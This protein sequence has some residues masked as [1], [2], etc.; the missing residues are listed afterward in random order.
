MPGH[1]ASGGLGRR[2]VRK[3]AHGNVTGGTILER[4]GRGLSAATLVPIK[5]PCYEAFTRWLPKIAILHSVLREGSKV[6]T[7]RAFYRDYF[8]DLEEDAQQKGWR[9]VAI[10]HS[11]SNRELTPSAV[12][13]PDEVT[14]ERL[15]RASVDQQI[16][17]ASRNWNT[18]ALSS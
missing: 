9:V 18:I 10:I 11:T 5:I 4:S 2:Q 3:I 14:A 7:V 13:S 17:T 12:V 15:G 16:A 8:I 1:L 6:R